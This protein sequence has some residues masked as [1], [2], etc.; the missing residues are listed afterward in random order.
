MSQTTYVPKFSFLHWIKMCKEP[1]CPLSPCLEFWRTLQV[2]DWY[3]GSWSWWWGVYRVPKNLYSEIQLPTSNKK[4]QRTQ[5]VLEVLY[6]SCGG[7][8]RFLTGVLV[9]DHDGEEFIISQTT[10]VPK[11]SFLHWIKRCKEPHVVK[12]L[13][14]N[15]GGLWRLLTGVWFLITM[16]R[17]L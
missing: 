14:W 12:V 11:F 5:H 7:L 16:E 9:L 17:G 4:V 13:D 6:W 2:S 10:Y 15:C 1:P 3:F 8:W